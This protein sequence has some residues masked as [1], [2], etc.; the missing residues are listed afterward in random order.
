MAKFKRWCN[1]I[2]EALSVS[3]GEKKHD[4]YLCTKLKKGWG[5]S[6]GLTYTNY[7]CDW[8]TVQVM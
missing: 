1:V 6:G 4:R 7:L 5:C 3:L 2:K 8:C